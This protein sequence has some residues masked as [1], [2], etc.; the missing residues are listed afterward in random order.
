[1]YFFINNLSFHSVK[2]A[3]IHFEVLS[4]LPFPGVDI[5]HVAQFNWEN[6]EHQNFSFLPS[7]K[8]YKSIDLYFK[9][10]IYYLFA[11]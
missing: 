4:K 11:K 6:F 8:Y 9:N 3:M 5:L 2:D 7:S 1:M 10:A